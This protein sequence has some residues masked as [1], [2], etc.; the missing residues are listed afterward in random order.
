MSGIEISICA[1]GC[2]PIAHPWVD[3]SRAPLY[4]V[5]FPARAE[6]ETL[7]AYFKAIEA[8]STRA[9]HS[10]AWV[11]NLTQVRAVPA[12]QRA[13]TAAYMRRMEAYDK[14]HTRATAFVI[15]NAV[16]RGVLTAI[17]W[18]TPP[19]FPR[20]VFA[21]HPAAAAWAREKLSQAR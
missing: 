15:S 10:V 6:D 18:V 1:M 16:I 5:T 8:W 21:E 17:F 9:Q 13:A 3:S 4:Q 12:S 14:L 2:T 19:V 7:N 11:M 20:E